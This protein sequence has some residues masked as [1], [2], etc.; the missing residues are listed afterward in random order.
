MEDKFKSDLFFGIQFLLEHQ[1]VQASLMSRLF[2]QKH[3][4]EIRRRRIVERQRYRMGRK[5]SA[6][7]KL[8]SFALAVGA[9]LL[10]SNLVRQCDSYEIKPKQWEYKSRYDVGY[11]VANEIAT[12]ENTSAKEPILLLNGFGVGSFHQHRLI[13]ELMASDDGS[14]D[15]SISQR[16]IYCMDYL[17]QGRSWPKDCQ[18]GLGENENDLQYSADT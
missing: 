3:R 10:L 15:G 9:Q 13:H 4:S 7:V 6:V 12:D 11:E 2:H 18:D 5:S 14:N 16:P 8:L 17:G 1:L